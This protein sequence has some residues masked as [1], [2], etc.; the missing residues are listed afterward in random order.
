MGIQV[1]PSFTNYKLQDLAIKISLNF[2]KYSKI[3][4][5]HELEGKKKTLNG[6][7]LKEYSTKKRASRASALRADGVQLRIDY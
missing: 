6:C 3:A 4:N 7:F 1:K 5:Y 2:Q